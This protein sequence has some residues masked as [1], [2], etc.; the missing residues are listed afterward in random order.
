MGVA[1]DRWLAKPSTLHF[2]RQLVTPCNATRSSYSRAHWHGVPGKHARA[3]GSA[4]VVSERTAEEAREQPF[5]RPRPVV[6]AGSEAVPE[7]ISLHVFLKA[8]V[9]ALRRW[10]PGEP[11]LET[12][13]QA[14]VNNPKTFGKLLVDNHKHLFDYTIWVEILNYRKR[15]HGHVG[16]LD[17]W[18][19][20]R[21]RDVD[22]PLNGAEAD[23]LWSE[24]TNAGAR[25][26][27]KHERTV[28]SPLSQMFEHAQDLKD[29]RG[30]YYTC[31]YKCIVGR[32]VHNIPRAAFSWHQKLVKAGMVEAGAI[33]GIAGDAMY[34][35]P[36][37]A[38]DAF[39]AF[40]AIYKSSQERNLYDSCMDVVSKLQD[41]AYAL[42]WHRLFMQHGDGPSPEM[43]QREDVQRIFERDQD[44]SLPMMRP[45]SADLGMYIPMTKSK[46]ADRPPPITR[47]SMNTIV[48]EVYG[49]K[50]KVISDSFCA[51]LLATH[52]L[53]LDLVLQSLSFFGIESLGP[54]AAREMVLR[55][56]SPVQFSNKLRDLK[57][58]G[59]TMQKSAYAKL[60]TTLAEEG[61]AG[62]WSAF[63]ESD[64][65]PE[66]YDDPKIQ[67]QLLAAFLESGDWIKAHLTLMV[68]TTADSVTKCRGWNRVIQHYIRERDHRSMLDTMQRIRDQGLPLTV[69]TLNFLW[70]IVLPPRQAGKSFAKRHISS[71]Y[72]PLTFC[73]NAF[74]YSAERG[75]YAPSKMWTELLKRHGMDDRWDELRR[76]LL[77][78]VHWYS[79]TNPDYRK[80]LYAKGHQN[81]RRQRFQLWT[82]RQIFTP[83]FVKAILTWGFR[84]GSRRGKLHHVPTDGSELEVK[85]T[86]PWAVGLV[87]LRKLRK[88]GCLIASSHVKDALVLRMWSLFGP[89][90]S[91]RGMN[92]E[93][94]RINELP[95]PHYIRYANKVWPNLINTVD[96][97]V[98][99]ETAPK[100][101]T[102]LVQLFG[103][104]RSTNRRKQ[105]Y[106]DQ[107]PPQAV[108]TRTSQ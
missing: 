63:V 74:I 34:A 26:Q 89:A 14:D 91:S 80:H 2:S 40:A 33:A 83:N 95:L 12:K 47:A 81:R 79:E 58:L 96:P 57:H 104:Y 30:T 69:R 101:A 38:N 77:W 54:M 87:L 45:K 53:S 94:R 5:L 55:S 97:S 23:T 65:H 29:R 76:L 72:D 21:Q 25:H 56:G 100:Q 84:H 70:L 32:C 88:Q 98:L 6:R 46:R 22:L 86:E 1:F 108:S 50:P 37:H 16:I 49:I 13:D 35:P 4:V 9:G 73:T 67:E 17:V 10:T 7:E 90:W 19:G 92:N 71:L 82:M 41:D 52:A 64:Q 68:L 31:L 99:D 60:A 66:S 20:M 78:M 43:F 59:I 107:I 28:A 36:A 3:Y 62:L 39:R 42:H 51:R 85:E 61:K 8:S 27:D 11:F 105:E 93:A 102:L 48:G 103:R 75:S 106:A 44:V 15:I 18:E 24:F